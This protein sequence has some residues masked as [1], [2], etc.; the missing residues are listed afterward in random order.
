MVLPALVVITLL[1][2]GIGIAGTFPTTNRAAQWSI[3]VMIFLL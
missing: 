1:N 2:M 3:V